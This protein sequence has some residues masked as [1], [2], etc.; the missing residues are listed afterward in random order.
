MTD[1]PSAPAPVRRRRVD[2]A[3][4][5][6]V[7]DRFWTP[8]DGT[9]LIVALRVGSD[10]RRPEALVEPAWLGGSHRHWRLVGDGM[11]RQA[12][13]EPDRPSLG[14]AAVS[15]D[16]RVRH[17]RFGLGTVI[18]VRHDQPGQ[19]AIARIR[20]DRTLRGDDDERWILLGGGMLRMAGD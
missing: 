17:D 7:G 14:L 10:S 6:S 19:Q 16:Q 15:V 5:W 20:F 18:E 1:R 12:P 2:R 11:V 9:C 4:G 13:G 8:A 3:G